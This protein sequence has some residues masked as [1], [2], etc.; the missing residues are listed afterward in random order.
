MSLDGGARARGDLAAALGG[1]DEAKP[2]YARVVSL[3][4]NADAGF[5]PEV[6]RMRAVIAGHGR[7]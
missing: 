5:R 7:P 1:M 6:N 3:W 2:W 4:A